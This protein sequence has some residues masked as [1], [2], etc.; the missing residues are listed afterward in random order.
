MGHN[1]I[2]IEHKIHDI[3]TWKTYISR[4]I[5]HQHWYTY[6]IA[7]QLRRN[8]HQKIFRLLSQQLS[9]LP[10]QPLRHQR[11][12]CHP[13]LNRFTRQIFTTVKRK[14]CP[15]KGAIFSWIVHFQNYQTCFASECRDATVCITSLSIQS[16]SRAVLNGFE[17]LQT[18]SVADQNNSPP[19]LCNKWWQITANDY[20]IWPKLCVVT[21]VIK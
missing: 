19:L 10:L 4:H 1:V 8:P 13:V 20:I 15:V 9:H 14:H 6:S 2:R 16:L 12:V 21:S 17:P 7:L 11:N 18:K 3:P 5:L